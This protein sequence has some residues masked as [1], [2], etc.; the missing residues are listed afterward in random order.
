MQEWKNRL[1]S[2]VYPTSFASVYWLSSRLS[3]FLKLSPDA[4]AGVLIAAPKLTQAIFAAL[5]DYY[6]WKLGERVYGQGSNEAWAA[7]CSIHSNQER[8]SI[9]EWHSKADACSLGPCS[10]P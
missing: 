5:G 1:R 8:I 10:S 3:Y 9:T 2:A 6:T 4:R 7:V